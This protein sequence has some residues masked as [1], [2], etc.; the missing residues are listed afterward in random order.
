MSEKV[1]TID[2]DAL[3]K[4]REEYFKDHPEILEALKNCKYEDDSGFDATIIG[5]DGM[6]K[7]IRIGN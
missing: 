4:R 3:Q 5:K 2:F 6:V 7:T 1:I